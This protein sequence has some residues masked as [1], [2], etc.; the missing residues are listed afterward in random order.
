MSAARRAVPA[1]PPPVRMDRQRAAIGCS[2]KVVA[3]VDA[4]FDG[5]SD[6][7]DRAGEVALAVLLRQI[8]EKPGML[9]RAVGR[10][11]DAY[12]RPVRSEERRV[13]KECRSRWA[14]YH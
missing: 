4:V 1:S 12:D 10:G 3:D 2:D 8:R 11:H 14:P 5:V 7:D 6:L 9:Q 13:G